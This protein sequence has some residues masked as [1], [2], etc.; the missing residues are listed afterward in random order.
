MCRILVIGF[1]NPLRGDDGVGWRIA[2]A[3]AHMWSDR[4]NVRTGQQLVP[5]WAADLAEA[6]IAFLVDAST[7]Q[8]ARLR[9]LPL[10]PADDAV[11]LDG[12]TVQ[13]RQLLQLAEAVFGRRPIAYLLEVPAEDF[14]FGE[15]L[16]PVASAGAKRAVRLLD[17]HIRSALSVADGDS[18]AE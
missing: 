6:D 7:R 17:R 2:D 1:G 18:H 12:H 4:I 14:E 13:P 5:E 15:T 10:S 9:L 11:V 3:V 8:R 16:S